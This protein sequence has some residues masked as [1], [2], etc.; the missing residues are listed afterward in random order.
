[1]RLDEGFQFLDSRGVT[2]GCCFRTHNDKQ[3]RCSD[4]YR[5]SDLTDL[6]SRIKA[7][8]YRTQKYHQAQEA[9]GQVFQVLKTLKKVELSTKQSIAAITYHQLGMVSQELREYEQARSHYQQALDIKIEYN[10]RYSQAS[11]YHQLGRVSQELREYEQARSHYQ[12]ALDIFIKYNDRY[13]QASTY[14]QLGSVAQ[15]LREYEQARSHY[16]Q[17]L[18]IFIEYNDRYSQASTYYQLG[19]VLEELD[20]ISEAKA[21]YLEDL[22]ISIEYDDKSGLATTLRNLARF[23]RKY[24]DSDFVAEIANSLNATVEEL[25]KLFEDFSNDE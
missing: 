22:K 17:A 21:C 5:F 1:M 7:D 10:D 24:P 9:Y 8:D 3:R 19:K 23:C 25:E 15:A 11:T 6:P 4:G 20:N 13:S 18:D 12:Q 14:H 2:G 16:Q